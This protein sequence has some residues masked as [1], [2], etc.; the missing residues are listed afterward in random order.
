MYTVSQ[1]NRTLE[2]FSNISNKAGPISIIFW[3]RESS[4][5]ML[6]LV[7]TILQCVVKQRTS[8]GFPLATRAEAGAP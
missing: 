3:Y 6:L 4:I 8:L 2:I 5:N 7:L 1:K